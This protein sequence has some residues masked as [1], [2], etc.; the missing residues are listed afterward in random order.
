MG[1][2]IINSTRLGGTTDGFRAMAALMTY[3]VGG[4]ASRAL[5]RLVPGIA[6]YT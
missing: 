6:G 2:R 4:L 5:S 3:W 1:Q